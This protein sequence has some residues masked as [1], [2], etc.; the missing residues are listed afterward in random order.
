MFRGTDFPR[1][2]NGGWNRE[3]SLSETEFPI[4]CQNIINNPQK[5]TL[6]SKQ[7]FQRHFRKQKWSIP[8]YTDICNCYAKLV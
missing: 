7:T 6:L 1:S 4:F 2:Q 8:D 3:K 5:H